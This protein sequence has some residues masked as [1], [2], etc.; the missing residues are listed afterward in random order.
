MFGIDSCSFIVIH[1]LPL[2]PCTEPQGRTLMP[3]ERGMDGLAFHTM[4]M[5]GP[6]ASG[7]T[8]NTTSLP[9][10]S[11]E[12]DGQREETLKDDNAEAIQ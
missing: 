6:F 1:P 12:V 10:V 2:K 11:A 9:V 7:M 5:P 8:S 4:A 3:T